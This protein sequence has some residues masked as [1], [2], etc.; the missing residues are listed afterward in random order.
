M[1]LT[2]NN[3][4]HFTKLYKTKGM[5]D[6]SKTDKITHIQDSCIS[7]AFNDDIERIEADIKELE[8]LIKDYRRRL[9][10]AGKI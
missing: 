10:C 9:S 6:C 7:I 3:C 5:G 4:R 2:C 8:W 1:K